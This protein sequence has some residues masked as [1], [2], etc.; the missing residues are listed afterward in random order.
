[1][2]QNPKHSQL[3]DPYPEQDQKIPKASTS[4]VSF[5]D[6]ML[7][8][9]QFD[10]KPIINEIP[11]KSSNFQN[12][13]EFRNLFNEEGLEAELNEE[14]ARE[15][16]TEIAPPSQMEYYSSQKRPKSRPKGFRSTEQMTE[17]FLQ[18][19]LNTLKRKHDDS[20]DES[21]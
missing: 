5:E 12:S 9:N 19:L 6:R 2:Q 21:D 17:S 18:G 20:D 14:L 8:H 3:H 16:R 1:M 7:L 10:S 11:Q 13:A 4:K 15:K